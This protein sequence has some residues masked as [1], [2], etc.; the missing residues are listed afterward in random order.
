MIVINVCIGSACHIKGSYNVI[1]SLQQLT[2]E[3]GLSNVVDTRAAFCL[4]HCT[5]AVSVQIN[6]GEVRSVSGATVRDFFINQVVPLTNQ[7][8]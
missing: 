7:Q 6:D 1:N 4:G 8:G 5:E 3:F 2:E